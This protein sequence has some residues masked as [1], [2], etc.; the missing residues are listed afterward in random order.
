LSL[1]GSSYGEEPA[2][3]RKQQVSSF[4]VGLDFAY[5]LSCR[6]ESN[7]FLAKPASVEDLTHWMPLEA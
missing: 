6:V 3:G 5:D 4:A 1:L 2:I 7:Q